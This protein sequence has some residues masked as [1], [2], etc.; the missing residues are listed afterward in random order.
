[1]KRRNKSFTNT[2]QIQ[3]LKSAET[4]ERV[5]LKIQL[6]FSQQIMELATPSA[7]WAEKKKILLVFLGLLV[8]QK[9]DESWVPKRHEPEAIF[10]IIIGSKWFKYKSRNL[11]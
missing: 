11:A 8:I 9:L 1:M 7:Q 3:K 6:N 10:R 4:S 2:N 5:E